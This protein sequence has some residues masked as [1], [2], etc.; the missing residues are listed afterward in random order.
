MNLIAKHNFGDL[1]KIAWNRATRTDKKVHALQNCF[2]CKIQYDDQGKD[3]QETYEPMRLTM[4]SLL[5]KDIKIFTLLSVAHRFDSKTATSHREYSYFLPT[6]TLTAI[7]DL[8]LESPPKQ[9]TQQIDD[10]AQVVTQ[11]SSGIKKILRRANEDDEHED[12]DKYLNRDLSHI[13]D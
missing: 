3:F 2:S 4:N 1:Q 8:N 11:V 12:F 6:Y 10:G 5:P 9:A 13:N 7:R